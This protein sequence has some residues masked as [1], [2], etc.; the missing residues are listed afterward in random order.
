[1]SD[2]IKFLTKKILWVLTQ[3]ATMSMGETQNVVKLGMNVKVLEFDTPV[4]S[5]IK[6]NLFGRIYL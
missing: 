2:K 4:R 1:M 5:A 3:N 6:L